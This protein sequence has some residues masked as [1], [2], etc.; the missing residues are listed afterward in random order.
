MFSFSFSSFSYS[1][2]RLYLLSRPSDRRGIELARYRNMRSKRRCSL[3]LQFALIL[4][5]GPV[6][7][8]L[9]SL[10]I[11]RLEWNLF[12]FVSFTSHSEVY[13]IQSTLFLVILGGHPKNATEYI[14]IFTS[15]LN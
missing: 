8:R 7:H 9:T 11:H 1:I 2:N 6:L 12:R 3:C 4:G 14:Y 10:V 15:I 5:A 13:S